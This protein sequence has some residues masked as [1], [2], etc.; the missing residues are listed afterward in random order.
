MS[1]KEKYVEVNSVEAEK[2]TRSDFYKKYPDAAIV[3]AGLT[4]SKGYAVD[5]GDD[6]ITWVPEEA[7]KLRF[8]KLEEL[9]DADVK[10]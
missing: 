7:F 1:N 9:P 6:Y 3:Q 2:M 5:Y 10:D 8:T 4:D